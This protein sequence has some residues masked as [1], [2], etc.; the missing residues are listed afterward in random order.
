MLQHDL[1]MLSPRLA[2]LQEFVNTNKVPRYRFEQ[3]K[4]A[5][6]KHKIQKYDQITNIPLDIKQPL[7]K[8]FGEYV[9]TLKVSNI[10]KSSQATKVG[11]I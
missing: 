4:E 6:Y 5:I 7:K 9:S 11:G 8:V 10:Q 1:L 3:I 2:Q